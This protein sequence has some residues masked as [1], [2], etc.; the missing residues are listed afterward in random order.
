MH[1]GLPHG[2]SC[3]EGRES[4]ALCFNL[5]GSS[6]T[7]GIE[8]VIYPSSIT[9]ETLVLQTVSR[10]V[11]DGSW[12]LI[13]SLLLFVHLEVATIRHLLSLSEQVD[14]KKR[15]VLGLKS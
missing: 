14:Y 10:S 5:I 3:L 6:Y 4:R 7:E 12:C 2:V 15:P 13:L 11:K 8:S 1:L 9:A